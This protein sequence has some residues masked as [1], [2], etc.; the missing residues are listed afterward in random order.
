MIVYDVPPERVARLHIRTTTGHL[1]FLRDLRELVARLEK[2]TELTP[3]EIELEELSNGQS[4]I[5]HA[6]PVYPA[7]YLRSA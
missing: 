7:T 1:N 4:L 3:V 2:A 5:I 6:V